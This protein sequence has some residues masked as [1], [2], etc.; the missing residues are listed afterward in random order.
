[1]DSSSDRNPV[2][3][4]AEEFMERKRR[5]ETPALSEYTKKYPQWAEEIEDLFPALELMEDF[6]PL[7]D[8]LSDGLH[9]T[10]KEA[11]IPEIHQI[12][13][14]RILREI[15]R[16]GMGV[17]YEAEQQSLGRRV[18]L[19]VLPR[20]SAGD[21]KSLARFQREA[22]AAAKMHHTN[23][24]P[25]FEV[26]QDQEHVF[27]AMQLIQGQGLD[28]VIGDLK[29]LRSHSL[30]EKEK[31][32]EKAETPANAQHE[33]AHSLAVSLVSGHFH[34]ERLLDSDAAP[35]EEFAAAPSTALA[36]TVLAAGGSTASAVLPGHSELSSA[37]RDRK[38]YF[39]SVAQIGLQTARALSY[40]HARGIV[41]RDIKPSNLL[42][43]TNGVVWVTDFGLAKTGDAGLTHSG[44]ILGTL[45]YMSPERFKGQ[46]DVRADVYSLGLTLF[47]LVT[48]KPAFESP[49][50]LKLIDMVAKTEMESPRTI[51]SR[52]PLDLETIILKAS[53]KDPKR[54]YQSA[55]DLAE[56]LQRFVDDEPILARR[57]T[58]I[59]RFARWSRR[60]P[61]LATAM[62]VAVLAL[63]A[64]AAIST[65]FAQTQ[66]G[67][68]KEI[69]DKNEALE[70]T[71]HEK[72]ELIDEVTL[73]NRTN[74]ELIADLTKRESDLKRSTATLAEKQAE[75]V[76][77]KGDLAEAMHWISRSYELGE[78]ENQSLLA[79]LSITAQKMPRLRREILVPGPSADTFREVFERFRG[80]PG[81]TTG[82]RSGSSRGQS[83]DSRREAFERSAQARGMSPDAAR[84]AFER[85]REARDN[86]TPSRS[87]S[88]RGASADTAQQFRNLLL[89]RNLI[90][91]SSNPLV[92]GDHEIIG[93]ASLELADEMVPRST[94]R[95]WD[96]SDQRWTGT[97]LRDLPNVAH[98]AIDPDH[99]LLAMVMLKPAETTEPNQ[100][101]NANESESRGGFASTERFIERLEVRELDTGEL[102]FDV[103]NEV[104]SRR[105]VSSAQVALRFIDN[106]A[107]LIK[108]SRAGD[109][110]LDLAIESFD[111]QS[112]ETDRQ[113]IELKRTGLRL[114]IV[115]PRL[116][117]S[118]DGRR[119][120]FFSSPP[121]RGIGGFGFRGRGSRQGYV[122]SFGIKTGEQ[123]GQQIPIDSVSPLITADDASRVAVVTGIG[124]QRRIEIRDFETGEQ[125]GESIELP[126]LLQS[127]VQLLGLSADRSKI[128]VAYSSGSQPTR[129]GLQ[130]PQSKSAE[131][132]DQE[133]PGSRSNVQVFDL[134]S[135]AAVTPP[136]SAHGSVKSAFLSNQGQ[137][138]TVRDDRGIR[139]WDLAGSTLR[140]VLLPNIGTQGLRGSRFA[141]QNRPTRPTSP[142]GFG[143][144]TGYGGR[145]PG[146]ANSTVTAA[147]NQRVVM[148]Q[149]DN[150]NVVQLTD[151]DGR[152][153]RMIR[154]YS[155]P[156]AP[157]RTGTV[158]ISPGG[159]FLLTS[160][161]ALVDNEN[162]ED[163]QRIAAIQVQVW[164]TDPVEL[165]NDSVD[166][167]LRETPFAIS[168]DGEWIAVQT[169]QRGSRPPQTGNSRPGR[170][171]PN[172][173]RGRP[174][175]SRQNETSENGRPSRPEVRVSLLLDNHIS[176]ERREVPL[177]GLSLENGFVG[178]ISFSANGQCLFVQT[179][180]V[181]QV[182]DLTSEKIE[183]LATVGLQSRQP[184]AAGPSGGFGGRGGGFGGG[185]GS[186]R[187]GYGGGQP[188]WA[189]NH[190]ATLIA[191]VV[192]QQA[193]RI[194]QIETRQTLGE[195][196]IHPAPVTSVCFDVEGQTIV[197][198]CEDGLV[199]QW[200]LPNAWS[201]TPEGIRQRVEQHTGLEFVDAETATI[202]RLVKGQEIGA[203]WSNRFGELQQTLN[204]SA[205]VALDYRH[206]ADWAAAAAAL[207]K[208]QDRRPDDWLPALLQIR[209]L[210]EQ[211]KPAEAQELFQQVSQKVDRKTLTAWI[212]AEFSEPANS[213]V[214]SSSSRYNRLSGADAAAIGWRHQ[215]LLG[216]S[217]TDTERAEHLFELAKV[218]EVELQFDE[219][220]DFVDQAT[221]LVPDSADMHY[222]RAH[223]MVRLGRWDEALESR[224]RVMQLEPDEH[225][226]YYRVQALSLF[227]ED[228]ESF[229]QAWRE[230]RDKWADSEEPRAP[231]RL[232]KPALILGQRGEELQQSLQLAD[233]AY[234]QREGRSALYD[235]QVKGLAELR[236]GERERESGNAAA[237][238]KHF[239]DAL[240]FT[241]ESSDLFVENNFNNVTALAKFQEAMI[242]H[243][244]E[245]DNE[246]RAAYLD[247][248]D[249]HN[250]YRMSLRTSTS[251]TFTDWLLNDAFRRSAEQLLGSDVAQVGLPLPQTE[252]WETIFEDR[253]D[254]EEFAEAWQVYNGEWRIED[255]AA[256]GEYTGRNYR[257][258][259]EA[260]IDLDFE[261]PETA[262]IE[263][264]SWWPHESLSELKLLPKLNI[265]TWG[266]SR[267]AAP[268]YT[269]GLS[270]YEHHARK[271]FTWNG[272]GAH[273]LDYFPIGSNW[274]DSPIKMRFLA[275]QE[276]KVRVFQQPERVTVFVDDG[277]GEVELFNER[278]SGP[279]GKFV[280][281]YGLGTPGDCIYFDNLKIRA[282]QA[283]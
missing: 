93:L 236:R 263:Y 35:P 261:V 178:E 247:A 145:L 99:R 107:R 199:R 148:L 23:I 190:D 104:P 68:N 124:G 176:G 264:E 65:V 158:L 165:L 74:E 62:S 206:R 58:A 137:T 238:Q 260:A 29:E 3:A 172:P 151:W 239:E 6:K 256:R 181:I 85:F 15:G 281:L 118:L 33:S 170:E 200:S 282:P 127:A 30:A 273:L 219:A 25:V 157:G 34:H 71:I 240:K 26:G 22:R 231:E 112:W 271:I 233:R 78:G 229:W 161:R 115:S 81:N 162:Q 133:A 46:C 125:V 53:D 106:G 164:R 8:D 209:P 194:R 96:L 2:E 279:M 152:T 177:P 110:P 82:S 248:F 123:L 41:H 97:V 61:W 163:Q 266:S 223:L 274:M 237:A 38:A 100:S 258:F 283:E 60:N 28:F 220:V 254:G 51:D 205:Q 203:E 212:R 11:S 139:V 251:N 13:D 54:R 76:A 255:G 10:K 182:F 166:L 79:K 159:S 140:N 225:F 167:N 126:V 184:N 227:L 183:R 242:L 89:L 116:D 7:S 21:E 17:V 202:K 88:G 268:S 175:N 40:A 90:S 201:G 141:G 77:E 198:A 80:T 120:I 64:V 245:R 128:I 150:R 197:T 207:E 208:W 72:E 221:M 250:S 129:P 103:E 108:V 146:V 224:R 196:L 257:E 217:Q 193:L 105:G 57:T 253:F 252:G 1:M 187:F 32:I 98:S 52:I 192:N 234:D 185:P 56:D 149:V 87:G 50:R 215:L 179:G 83:E 180:V 275:G 276:Y 272:N 47:E 59:E 20:S 109:T 144:R 95:F 49:D 70:E 122:A 48:L 66:Y 39:H 136:L 84:E 94:M 154:D 249:L 91:A 43:D 142:G 55:D 174:L 19:K 132:L 31:Q 27:Y 153:G 143:N 186:G 156:F 155:V 267:D 130:P 160:R 114:T 138:L 265:A 189:I 45:R 67:L 69:V 228:K 232:A 63:I 121:P 42:L 131:Q 111:C 113:E 12:G 73:A 147:A 262:E 246:A 36:E 269:V 191:D 134:E 195:L 173:S 117:I 16:G 9:S 235:I 5:G 213:R 210:V 168:P 102:L 243:H 44:D 222:Y 216:V 230:M 37:E 218:R 278:I 277:S 75:Y 188:V 280:R 135:G 226:H 14:Y 18:A 92:V 259:Q 214:A 270:G 204:R 211:Q 171:E 101:A 244:L 86:A 119:L 24:V 241:Q 169:R 4:L